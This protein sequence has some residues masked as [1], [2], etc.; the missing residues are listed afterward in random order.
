[1][2]AFLELESVHF[3][4]NQDTPLARPVLKDISLSIEAGQFIGLIGPTGSGKSTLIQLF[5]GLLKPT[6]GRVLLRGQ[7]VGRAVTVS[8]ACRQI[9]VA[10]QFPENQLFEETV[11]ADIAFGPRNLG[12]SAQEVEQSVRWAMAAVGLRFSEFKDR[13]PFMLSGGETRRVAIAGVL[14]MRPELLVL[15]E[16]TAGLDGP[17]QR[18]MFRFLSQLQTEYQQTVF[19][20][21]HNIDELANV[22]DRILVLSE[23]RIVADEKP[24][25]VFTQEEQLTS[26]GLRP[27]QLTTLM[28]ALRKRG[29]QVPTEVFSVTEA[30]TAILEVLGEGDHARLSH[31]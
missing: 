16:P 10:F 7:E 8:S 5:N 19:L 22:A 17:G 18:E 6:S 2:P 15:D 13:S 11:F 24:Q 4:Y 14:A 12:L 21:S 20:V 25:K 30:E 27:P 31:P 23:G 26:W 28:L 9:G 29:L 3:T 1:M